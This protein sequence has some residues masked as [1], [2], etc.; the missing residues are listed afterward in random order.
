MATFHNLNHTKT[1][2]PLYRK[3]SHSSYSDLFFFSNKEDFSH[4]LVSD[5]DLGYRYAKY[6]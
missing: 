6:L 2:I 3:N 4:G 5:F 1:K